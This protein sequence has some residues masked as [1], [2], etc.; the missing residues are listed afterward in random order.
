MRI[1]ITGASGFIGYNLSRYL[2]NKGYSV[3]AFVRNPDNMAHLANDIEIVKGDVTN[4][5]SLLKAFEKVDVVIHLAALFNHPEA[6]WDDYNAV[7]VTGTINVLN[8]AKN[9]GVKKVIHC[10]TV[11]VA[12]GT[13][14]MPYNESTEYSAPEWDKYETT[15]CKGEQAALEFHRKQDYPVVVIRPAQPFGPGDKSKTKF[16]KMVRKGIIVNPGNT[17]KHLIYIDDLCRAFELA[18]TEE[19]AIGEVVIIAGK[20]ATLLKD[21]IKIAAK[22]LNVPAPKIIIPATLMTLLCTI[23]EKVCNLIKIKPVLFRRS[24]DFFTKSV[25]FDVTKA[26][27]TL[28]FESTTEVSDGVVETIK[29]YK[30]EGLL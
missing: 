24:M 13:G 15:K 10:S 12:S 26:K 4:P 2:T 21:L 27:T 20:E 28:G 16:Y 30:Q 29:Y 19:K 7:N 14:N 3:V 5:E 8:A 22:E 9:A 23:T 17:Y 25:E 18:I 11:G 6:S 1:A